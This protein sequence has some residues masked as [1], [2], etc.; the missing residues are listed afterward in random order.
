LGAS[1]RAGDRLQ[2]YEAA[3]KGAALFCHVAEWDSF[4]TVTSGSLPRF[5]IDVISSHDPIV[6]T[7]IGKRLLTLGMF[8]ADLWDLPAPLAGGK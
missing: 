2:L 8:G 4:D 6:V 7:G 5:A 1:R 3:P